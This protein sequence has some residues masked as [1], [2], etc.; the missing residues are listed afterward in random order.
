MSQLCRKCARASTH[1]RFH[2]PLGEGTVDPCLGLLKPSRWHA[3]ESLPF[4][5][6]GPFVG[7]CEPPDGMGCIFWAEGP[8]GRATLTW[9]LGPQQPWRR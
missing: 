3:Q 8:M 1:T 7:V 2:F 9:L 6:H 5:D 4:E